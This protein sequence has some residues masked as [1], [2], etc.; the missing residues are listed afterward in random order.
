MVVNKFNV[1]IR[2]LTRNFYKQINSNHKYIYKQI[3][4]INSIHS[5]IY[6]KIF[7]HTNFNT[8]Q[9]SPDHTWR[10]LFFNQIRVIRTKQNLNIHS[11]IYAKIFLNTNFN[12]TQL[13]PVHTW[14]KLFFNQIRVIRT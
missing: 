10:K 9:L 13:S 2:L 5:I 1:I 4:N 11:I 14:R 7:L 3:L 6:S 12:T 8:T